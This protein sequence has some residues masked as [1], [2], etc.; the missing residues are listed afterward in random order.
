MRGNSE[1]KR[2]TRLRR[3]CRTVVKSS[4]P[5][6][7]TSLKAEHAQSQPSWLLVHMTALLV[8]MT[9]KIKSLNLLMQTETKTM[10]YAKKKKKLVCF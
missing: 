9:D 6:R 10:F 2:T 5:K 3:N 7:H 4:I 1:A 8:H